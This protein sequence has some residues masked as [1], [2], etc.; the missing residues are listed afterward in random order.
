MYKAEYLPS[1][2]S[3]EK[4]DDCTA[5]LEGI[6]D[7]LEEYPI[8]LGVLFGSRARGTAG[9]HSDIDIAV[10]FDQALSDERRRRAR[11]KLLVDLTQKLGTDD[12]DV[13]DLD[14]VVPKIGASALGDGIILVG[15]DERAEVL[16]TRFESE[17]SPESH[18]D[19]MNRF[20][21]LLTEMENA[22]DA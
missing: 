2:G 18:E 8:R 17:I 14:G 3:P 20:D 22:V 13:T 16:Q 6:R 7:V 1:M 11:L 12:I 9:P 4:E 21:D 10:K 19:R 15:S 5:D